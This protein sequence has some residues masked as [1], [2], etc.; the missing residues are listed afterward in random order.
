MEC[1]SCFYQCLKY[2]SVSCLV[3][4]RKIQLCLI[5]DKTDSR[6]YF[7]IFILS[8]Y[9]VLAFVPGTLFHT[10][11]EMMFNEVSSSYL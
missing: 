10:L 4:T 7:T 6:N 3:S 9:V 2:Y 8:V 5:S 1:V 11:S